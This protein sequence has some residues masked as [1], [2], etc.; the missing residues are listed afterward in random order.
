MLDAAH[1]FRNRSIPVDNIVQDWHYWGDLG[2]G[3]QW[4]P[5]VYPDPKAMVAE[6]KSINFQL[7]VSVWS[8][9]DNF[10]YFFKDMTSKGQMLNGTDYYDPWNSVAREQF[11]QY[12]KKAHFDIG[13][14]NSNLCLLNSMN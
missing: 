1:G 12:S 8:K 3:P 9:Y 5:K 13:V 2:W 7:M 11:Y 14:E 4:D 6:L 10:T